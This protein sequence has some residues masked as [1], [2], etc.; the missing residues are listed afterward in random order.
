MTLP[1]DPSPCHEGSVQKILVVLN[2]GLPEAILA[3]CLLHGLR[4]RHPH[5]KITALVPASQLGAVKVHPAIDGVIAIPENAEMALAIPIWEETA[6]RQL[7]NSIRPERFDLA[8]A[9]SPT[10][11]ALWTWPFSPVMHPS[12]SAGRRR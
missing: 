2:L 5:A 6:V 10:R 7:V 9:P 8:L 12:G 4:V 11:N 1:K 3:G